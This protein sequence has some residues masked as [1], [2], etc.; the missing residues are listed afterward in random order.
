MSVDHSNKS[1]KQRRL[2]GIL[3]VVIVIAVARGTSGGND[4]NEARSP[5]PTMTASISR[6]AQEEIESYIRRTWSGKSWYDNVECISVTGDRVEVFTNLYVDA[7]GR[8][9]AL[10]IC[11]AVSSIIY[12]Y[13]TELGVTKLS[14]SGQRGLPLMWS[15]KL[16]DCS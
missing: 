7:E 15:S 9:F 13:R 3:A 12:K 1:S 11:Q 8:Q 16:D 10:P 2:G 6:N 4:E 14:I 5:V